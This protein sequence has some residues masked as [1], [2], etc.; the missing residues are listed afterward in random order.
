MRAVVVHEWINDEGIAYYVER[1][2]EGGGVER[3][4]KYKV[5]GCDPSWNMG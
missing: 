3:G 4:K 5:D 2:M 1:K